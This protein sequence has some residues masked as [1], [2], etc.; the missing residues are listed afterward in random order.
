MHLSLRKLGSAILSVLLLALGIAAFLQFEPQQ[1]P[2]IWPRPVPSKYLGWIIH[3]G[4]P[5]NRGRYS[6]GDRIKVAILDL[7]FR[8]Y[9]S[10]LKRTLPAE[11][12][13]QSTR[14]D[15][16]LEARDSIHGILC[17][18]IVHRLA[19][20]AELLFANW[21]PD[22]PDSFLG[23]VLWARDRGARI[24]CCSL[25]MPT[26]SDGDGR[27]MLHEKL[28]ELLSK[29]GSAEALFFACTGNMA[30]RHWSG[31]YRDFNGVHAWR[32]G[33][34]RNRVT[35]W[36]AESVS[37]E[38]YAQPGAA[39]E[40]SV[41]DA[42]RSVE[43]KRV[44]TVE[45]GG[46][47]ATAARIEPGKD[48][49]YLVQVT[50]TGGKPGRFHLAVLSANLEISTPES[51]IPFPGDGAEV[52]TVGGI[53]DQGKRRPFSACGPIS[54]SLKPDLMAEVPVPVQ[55]RP[56]PFAGTSAAAP[57]AAGL[58]AVLW[59]RHPEWTAS[60]VRSALIRAAVD[61]GPPGHDFETG[62]GRLRL[63]E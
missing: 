42:V 55:S 43:V 27:G 10:F 16:N 48:R 30:E 13:V 1:L 56:Q 19:P 47:V 21:D 25:V 61:L 60:E 12:T 41:I 33:Q 59:S 6:D 4:P 51:S 44:Q 8:G 53:D 63:P 58:A 45:A 22:Q 28:T 49:Q 18:E 36:G 7:G 14:A 26:W 38:L 17:G 34:T 35:P 2:Q 54:R 11:V 50:P 37:I 9:R 20:D 5:P 57:Q 24:I 62:H 32:P 40:L 15:G 3:I 39:Y 31:D 29:D 46:V 52:I 23:A